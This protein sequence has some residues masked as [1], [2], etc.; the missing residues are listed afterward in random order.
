[1]KIVGKIPAKFYGTNCPA[2]MTDV[3][4]NSYKTV[5]TNGRERRVQNIIAWQDNQK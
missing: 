1:M 5:I 4:G 3:D 2:Y